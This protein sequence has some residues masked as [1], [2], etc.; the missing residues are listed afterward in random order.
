MCKFLLMLKGTITFFLQ[1]N[2]FKYHNYYICIYVYIYI[3]ILYS[4][5][6]LYAYF[7]VYS[8]ICVNSLRRAGQHLIRCCYYKLGNLTVLQ[9]YWYPHGY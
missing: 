7:C 1:T 3:Y 9:T 4:F 2:F 8:G 6:Y 5:I